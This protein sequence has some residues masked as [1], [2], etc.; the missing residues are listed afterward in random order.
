[1]P[2][3]FR[4]MLAALLV[5]AAAIPARAQTFP[6]RTIH[7]VVAYAPGGT[8]D[9]VARLI[10]VPLAEAL[11]QNIVIEPARRAPSARRRWYRRRPTATRC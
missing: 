2:F 8:G 1:M 7:I 5:F 4:L 6:S 9:I 10:A 3:R 11:G